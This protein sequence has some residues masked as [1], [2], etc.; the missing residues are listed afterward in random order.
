MTMEV[1]LVVVVGRA[2]ADK[3]HMLGTGFCCKQGGYLA[4]TYHVIRPQEGHLVVL[5][6]HA[7]AATGYQDLTDTS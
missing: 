7:N 2:V 3:V 4:T 5:A 6:P 1:E